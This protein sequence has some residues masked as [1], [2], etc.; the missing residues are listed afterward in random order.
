VGILGPHTRACYSSV[1]FASAVSSAVFP[2]ESSLCLFC[3]HSSALNASDFNKKQTNVENVPKVWRSK[4][5]WEVQRV[6]AVC[7]SA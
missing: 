4:A 5:S 3:A 7:L 6:R 2:A 1:A